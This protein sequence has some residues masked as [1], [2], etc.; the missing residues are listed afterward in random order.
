MK[1]KRI[2]IF[3]ISLLHLLL[4]SGFA[5]GIW[6]MI[7]MTT[8]SYVL[9]NY[10]NPLNWLWTPALILFGIGYAYLV[11]YLNELKAHYDLFK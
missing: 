8:T 6:F 1:H 2:F 4:C 5:I 9:Y 10:P 3:I 7:A 11:K